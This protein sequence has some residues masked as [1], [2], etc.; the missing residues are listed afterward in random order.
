MDNIVKLSTATKEA[1]NVQKQ[2]QRKNFQW[3]TDMI[4]HLIDCLLDYK[5]SMTLKN[6]DFDADKPM[7]YKQVRL[8][9]ASIYEQDVALLGLVQYPFA[10]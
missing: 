2:A 1:N 5:S 6:L 4:E 8:A 3:E 7:Q 9:M 10:K